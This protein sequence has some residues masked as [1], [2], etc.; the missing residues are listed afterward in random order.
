MPEEAVSFNVKPWREERSYNW[1]VAY[2]KQAKLRSW[3][4]KS[5]GS[6]SRRPIA[7]WGGDAS[8]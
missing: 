6:N 7:A 8:V 2:G 3:G 1:F 4:F 5:C